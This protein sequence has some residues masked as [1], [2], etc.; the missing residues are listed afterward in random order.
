MPGFT[1]IWFQQDF[2]VKSEIFV[3]YRY[4]SRYTGKPH[5]ISSCISVTSARTTRDVWCHDATTVPADLDLGRKEGRK[6]NSL[7]DAMT[8][9]EAIT[10]VTTLLETF[11]GCT[12]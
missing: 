11:Q 4:T 3:E 10:R 6:G 12:R 5:Q 2:V 7:V 9:N 1:R 8:G